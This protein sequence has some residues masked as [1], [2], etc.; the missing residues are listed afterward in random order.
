MKI[1]LDWLK[2][3]NACGEARREFAK[4]FPEGAEYQDVLDALAAENN[5]E[6]AYWLMHA[7]G[8]VDTVLE[9]EELTAEASLFFAGKVIVKGA[10]E[11][12]KWILAGGGIEAGGGIKAGEG[13]EAGGGI[14]AGNDFGIYAGLRLRIS[15]KAEYAVVKAKE[16][17]N[18][19][20][21][22]TFE[23]REKEV[24]AGA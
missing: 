16:M 22:G 11:V 24:E 10:I 12:A 19:L 3:K 9:V 1:T 13:I 17:P 8:P 5:F 23:K 15:L 7:A 21:L 6:W 4:R 2:E 14:E 18:N 20:L